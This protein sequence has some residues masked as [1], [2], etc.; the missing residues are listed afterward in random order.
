[1]KKI[2]QLFAV[3]LSISII[4]P[5]FVFASD[6]PLLIRGT[7]VLGMGGAFVAVSDDQNAFFYNPAGI[8]QRQGALFTLFELP[9]SITNDSI[10][11]YNYYNAHQDQLKNFTNQSI[12]VQEQIVN[13]ILNTVSKYKTE[14]LIGFPNTSY[15]SSGQQT[16]AWGF[17]VFD[18]ADIGFQFVPDLVIPKLHYFGS[19]NAEAAVPLAHRFDKLP[20]EVP[21]KLSVGA[22]FKYIGRG[23]IDQSPSVLNLDNISITPQIGKGFG[24]DLGTLYQLN[25]RWNFGLQVTDVGGT[26]IF[27]DALN[28]TDPNQVANA[29]YTSIIYPQYNFGTAYIPSRIYYWPGHYINSKDRII[30]V[31]DVRDLGNQDQTV[32]SNYFWYKLHLGAELRWGPLSIRGGFNQGYPTIGLGARIPYLGLKVEYAYWTDELGQYA[33]QIPETRH[34]LSFALSWGDAKGRAYG[35]DVKNEPE[36]EKEEPKKEE[37]KPALIPSTTSQATVPVKPNQANQQAIPPSIAPNQPQGQQPAAAAEAVKPEVPAQTAPAAVA[38]PAAA[39][40]TANA[41]AQTPKKK[42]LKKKKQTS[43]GN[44]PASQSNAK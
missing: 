37:M 6:S 43:A 4:F 1:M 21:G 19:V 44:Q 30:F 2:K 7:R 22:T 34:Q 32:F 9:V 12:N 5:S 11:F 36:K 26:K 25:P 8:T 38:A 31:A 39:S 20:F 15:L 40:A 17:G 13:D 33:G 23:A 35:S 28:P 24:C 27:Y 42:T 18:Q 16:I 3:L 14:L 29:A 41:P 10:D